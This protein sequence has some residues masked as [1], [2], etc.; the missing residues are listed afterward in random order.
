MS[1]P[2][3]TPDPA[4]NPAPV[5]ELIDAFRRSKTMFAAVSLGVFEALHEGPADASSL[6]ARLLGPAAGAGPLER[7]LDA[8]VGM[9]CSTS[10]TELTPTSLSPKLTCATIARSR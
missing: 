8:C 2:D 7:L 1:V 4:P 6:A 10:G 5:L 9:G 3:P